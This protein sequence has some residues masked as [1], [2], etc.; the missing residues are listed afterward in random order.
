MQL[1]YKIQELMS[2]TEKLKAES[3]GLV[4]LARNTLVKQAEKLIETKGEALANKLQEQIQAKFAELKAQEALKEAIEG[5]LI[6]LHS[7]VLEKTS[8]E[9]LARFDVQEL[10]KQWGAEFLKSVRLNEKDEQKILESVQTSMMQTLGVQEQ[11]LR[12]ETQGRLEA[13]LAKIELKTQEELHT[14]LADLRAEFDEQAPRLLEGCVQKATQTL[15]FSF[16]REKPELFYEAIEQNLKGLF[17]QELQSEFLNTWVKERVQEEL[18]KQ[19]AL[20]KF[21]AMEFEAQLYLSS[22]L[23]ANAL[24]ML[25]EEMMLLE[26]NKLEEQKFYADMAYTLQK[27]EYLKTHKIDFEQEG[28]TKMYKVDLWAR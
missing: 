7:E 19:E 14:T 2:T 9:L 25:Q 15:D 18:D 23:H 22:L 4:E 27:R 17:W 3:V 8:L 12:Q 10:S 6:Q 1:Y 28:H 26:R 21:K 13:F 20:E 11:S 5:A 24:K 16:L